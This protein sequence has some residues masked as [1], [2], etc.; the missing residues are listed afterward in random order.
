MYGA[1]NA[2][3][4]NFAKHDTWAACLG[5]VPSPEETSDAA[6]FEVCVISTDTTNLGRAFSFIDKIFLIT[7][8]H[9][10]H[11]YSSLSEMVV[12]MVQRHWRLSDE[13]TAKIM[14]SLY[15]K[16][17]SLSSWQP[18]LPSYRTLPDL[19]MILILR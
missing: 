17:L 10:Q 5:R 3:E 4:L 1:T 13:I 6:V 19:S 14:E 15:A 11:A 16:R 18:K 12:R 2:T 7:Y 8:D 9:R